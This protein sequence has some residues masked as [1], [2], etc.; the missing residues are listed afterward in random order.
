VNSS[1]FFLSPKFKQQM[2][3]LSAIFLI[4]F[5]LLA[6]SGG[7][8][9][10]T[11]A[12]AKDSVTATPS[13]PLPYTAVYSST[14]VPGKPVDVATVLNNYKA[15]Q[16]NDM[17]ALR[18]TIGDS[19]KMIFSDGMGFNSTGDS[20]IKEAKKYRDSL[21]RVDFTFYAWTSN[22]SVDK[23][24]D[25]VNVWYKE[26]DTYKTGK[27]DSANYEDDNRLKDGKI[28]WTSTHIQKFAKK[29]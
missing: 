3:K 9:D 7:S 19:L 23:N 24:E 25:W 2:K 13:I 5:F 6:C 20:A 11:A 10:S 14:F 18:A 22:Y 28:V 4:P 17:A 21:S 26:V 29:K 8:T 27:V 16:D 1:G 12:A 15:W